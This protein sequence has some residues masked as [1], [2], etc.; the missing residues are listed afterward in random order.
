MN[1]DR[2][3]AF[4]FVDPATQ[5]CPYPFYSAL[6]EE[7]PVYQVPQTGFWI[8][9]RYE[10][11]QY[12][13]QHPEL[14]SSRLGFR[15]GAQSAE[16]SEIYARDGFGEPVDTLVS[17]DPPSHTRYRALVDKAFTPE[18]VSAMERY[19]AD[20]CRECLDAFIDRGEADIV[21]DYAVPIPLMV[22]A[23]QLG[24]PRADMD[25]FK[26]WS[27]SSVAPLG[28]MISREQAIACARDMVEFQH[29]FA[30]R[31]EAVRATPGDDMVSALVHARLDD[32]TQLDTREL[33]SI[34]NQL[35]VA[36]NET[37]TNAIA[38]GVKLLCENPD[39]IVL[40]RQDPGLHVRLAE[41]VLRC[42]SP[43]QGLFR[44]TTQDVPVAGTVIP[45]G[46]LVNIR[47]GAANRDTARF[48]DGERFDVRR[49][50]ANRHMAFGHGIHHCIG[51]LLARQELRCALR[52]LV[53][54]TDDLRLAVD[55]AS[56][57]HHP[58]MILRGLTS[59]PVRF[60]RR[61]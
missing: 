3:S 39:Q 44:M 40:L 28:R 49:R 33:L 56:L 21:K 11:V 59:L 6:R 43:V 50:N 41:E 1:T 42:E 47:Y 29:Y 38:S 16:V 5:E 18:R 23:D 19:I 57:R 53:E 51:H 45:A 26:R 24:V 58:S 54:R 34:L 9:S 36:G 4:N 61:A 15:A 20:I 30:A 22:I 35:L 31:F 12:A 32:D 37:T 8:I 13:L 46:S 7:A 55:A 52:E 48:E 27:D 60:T 14:F 2:L 17:N 10:D 25:R